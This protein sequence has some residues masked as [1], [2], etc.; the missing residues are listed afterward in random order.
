M[1]IL[2]QYFEKALSDYADD[3][4]FSSRIRKG[5]EAFDKYYTKTDDCPLYAAA[6][7]LHPNRRIKYIH[8]NWKVKWQKPVLKKAKELWESY[9]ERSP[10]P[11]ISL[12]ERKSTQG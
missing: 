8:A 10:S 11:S 6:L 7:I 5:W 3:K 1:D 12:Y 4:E 2:V 9:R